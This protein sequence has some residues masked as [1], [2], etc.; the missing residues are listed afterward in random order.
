MKELYMKRAIELAKMGIGFVNPGPL[1]GAVIVKN[2]EIIGEGYYSGYKEESA[3]QQAL[4]NS[5][6]GTKGSELYINIQPSINSG[7]YQNSMEAIIKSGVRKVYIGTE[8]KTIGPFQDSSKLLR[9]AGIE[10]EAGVLRDEC[11][12]LN[13][14]FLHYIKEG[15]PFVFTKWAMT[16]D[17]KLAT[18]TG[19]SKWI[20][21]EE[22]LKFVHHL[23]QRVAAIMVG[24]NTVRLDNPMLTTRLEGV[25]ISNPLRVILSKYGDIAPGANVLNIDEK[26]KTLIIAS[27]GISKTKE[28][29]LLE[30]GAE[31]LKLP[32]INGRLDF[33]DIV[34][35]LGDMGIDS[36]YIEGGSSILASAFESGVVRKVYAA[37][38]PKIIGGKDAFT[39]VG[40]LG[41]EK[42]KDAIVLNKVSHEIVGN[43]VIFIGYI[44]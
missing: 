35:A 17:G 12:E 32:E 41:I 31:L 27:T 25:E 19:D 30:R 8:V 16:L 6:K 11:L 33:K 28:A 18:R 2:S 24:E 20:S 23:R 15:T 29:Y 38:A 43:D 26:T 5:E 37:V 10:V 4:R 22:S 39:P 44:Y 34:I 1:C 13:E 42:M 36:L 40:G 21:G 7:S 14:I 9:D 3:E